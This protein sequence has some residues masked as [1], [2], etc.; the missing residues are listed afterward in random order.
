MLQS[1]ECIGQSTPRAAAEALLPWAAHC[2]APVLGFKGF[3]CQH[4]PKKWAS[5]CWQQTGKNFSRD[6]QAMSLK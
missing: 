5:L 4:V 2:F 6:A 1:D 3:V